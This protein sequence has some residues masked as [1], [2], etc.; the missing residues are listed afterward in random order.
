MCVLLASCQGFFPPLDQRLMAQRLSTRPE[1][2]GERT[3]A[4]ACRRML[5]T[6]GAAAQALGGGAGAGGETSGITS[7]NAANRTKSSVLW[8][9][10]RRTP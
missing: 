6:R 10:T 5:A 9:S 7:M 3:A 8:V 2:A 1:E 4:P